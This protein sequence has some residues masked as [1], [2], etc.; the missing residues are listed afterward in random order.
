VSQPYELF[1]S[2]R[3]AKRL[4]PP[5]VRY[6]IHHPGCPALRY[7]LHGACECGGSAYPKGGPVVP[8][9]PRR[10]GVA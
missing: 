9:P 8:M 1:L 7:H 2:M 10:P 4:P 5:G 3:D 6:T